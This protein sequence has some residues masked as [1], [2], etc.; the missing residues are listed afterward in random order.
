MDDD[1]AD[2]SSQ[3]DQ[4]DTKRTIAAIR[5]ADPKWRPGKVLSGSSPK[6][7]PDLVKQKRALYVHLASRI[8]PY[9]A[10]RL[11]ATTAA[12]YI[13]VLAVPLERLWDEDFITQAMDVG[14]EII[15]IGPGPTVLGEPT[16]LLSILGDRE[17][18]PTLGVRRKLARAGW[19]V[20]KGPAPSSAVKGRRLEAVI[21]FLVAQ[22]HDFRVVERNFR[23]A[24]E[25][26]D[27]VVQHRGNTRSWARLGCPY[28]LVE[29]KNW[30]ERVN[31]ASFSAF[32]TKIQGKRGT[33]RIGLMVSAAGF[34]DEARVQEL[35]FSSED[36]TVVFL[37]PDEVDGLIEAADI[38]EYLEG[39]VRKAMLR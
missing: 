18:R 14:T 1:V 19:S 10:T 31:Q 21:S 29:C 25:E 39:L 22:V 37:G 15:A 6:I 11:R 17:I 28:L 34:T 38:D 23:T 7:Q 27:I 30:G 16:M 35:R 33:V 12:G 36:I 5:K 32:R 4:T 3:D 26:L 20:A 24:T 2:E 8:R 9:L 13:P